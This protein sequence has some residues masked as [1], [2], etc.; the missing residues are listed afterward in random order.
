MMDGNPN[1]MQLRL[2]QEFGEASGNTLIFG[3]PSQSVPVPI[4]KDV[5]IKELKGKATRN[6]EQEN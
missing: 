5:A 4:S 3:M 6:R 2:L 1:L